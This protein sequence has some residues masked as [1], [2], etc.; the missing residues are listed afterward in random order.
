MI[1]YIENIKEYIFKTISI[2]KNST[3]LWDYKIKS[4]KNEVSPAN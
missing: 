4:Q 1:T 3:S 2:N